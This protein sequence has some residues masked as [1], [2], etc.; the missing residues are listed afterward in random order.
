MRVVI[1]GCTWKQNR[2]DYS[3][4]CPSTAN[5]QNEV[6]SFCETCEYDGCNGAATLG[7]TLALLVAPLGLLIF[8]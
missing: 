7:T 8:K 6:T 5:R 3:T 1:R 2:D 4:A